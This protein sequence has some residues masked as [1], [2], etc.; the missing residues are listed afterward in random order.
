MKSRAIL[1]P[2]SRGGADATASRLRSSWSAA[3]GL[4]KSSQNHDF[5]EIFED[6]SLFFFNSNFF[7]SESFCDSSDVFRTYSASSVDCACFLGE[8]YVVLM[9]YK[10]Y[11]TISIK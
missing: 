6:F 5:G 11:N 10:Y 7:P 1:A 3:E 4:P 9:R 2:T 8:L